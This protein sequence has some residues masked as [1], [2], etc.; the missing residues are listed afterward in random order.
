MN[1]QQNILQNQLTEKYPRK[2]KLLKNSNKTNFVFHMKVIHKNK[3][4]QLDEQG[5]NQ[6]GDN[7]G[8]YRRKR[9]KIIN[10]SNRN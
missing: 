9:K 8:S 7:R 4:D 3:Q 2:T 5:I 6:I 10:K 1:Y